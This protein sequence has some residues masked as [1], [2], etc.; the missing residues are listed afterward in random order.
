VTASV[1]SEDAVVF[2][3]EGHIVRGREAIEKF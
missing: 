2:P 3:P 1:Y